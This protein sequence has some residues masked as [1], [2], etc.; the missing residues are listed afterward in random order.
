MN[1][2]YWT[3]RNPETNVS[4]ECHTDYYCKGATPAN[5]V[6]CRYSSTDNKQKD[7]RELKQ[8]VTKEL[9]GAT[10]NRCEN[11]S[12]KTPKSRDELKGQDINCRE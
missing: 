4:V 12:D 7:D 6:L 3:C 11:T 5:S 1:T 9:R 10:S 2:W 8:D